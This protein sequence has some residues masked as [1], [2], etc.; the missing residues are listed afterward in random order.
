MSHRGS[1]K[2]EYFKLAAFSYKL[3]IIALKDSPR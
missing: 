3:F 1:L 2:G